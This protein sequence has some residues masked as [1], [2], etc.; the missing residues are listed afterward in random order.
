[1][2]T[3]LLKSN[4]PIYC[5]GTC[6]L[7]AAIG[8][9]LIIGEET[10]VLGYSLLNTGLSYSQLF[11]ILILALNSD[12]LESKQFRL[13]RLC[14]SFLIVAFAF[15][16]LH[17]NGADL[18]L[19][20]S[21]LAFFIVY[22]TRFINKKPITYSDVLKVGWL[23]CYLAGYVFVLH[24]WPFGSELQQAGIGIMIILVADFWFVERRKKAAQSQN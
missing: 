5:F 14:I 24:H 6:L 10:R 20:L 8:G 22:F 23:F 7:V 1:M 9:Y 13:F 16:I 3:F 19:N 2:K 12:I 15:K 4:I 21:A 11:G 18:F 17:W